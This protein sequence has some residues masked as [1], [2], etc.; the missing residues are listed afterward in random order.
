MPAN[1]SHLEHIDP[2]TQGMA[3]AANTKV[4]EPGPPQ[5]FDNASL[6]ILIHGDASFPGQGIVSET[7]SLSRLPGYST[8]GSLH[9][10]TNNQLGFTAMENESRSSLH[11]SDLAKGFEIPIIHV[12][13]DDPQACIE[14]A[15]T[16][17]AYRHKFHKD[18]VINLIGYP[19]Y[20]HNKRD[21]PRFTHPVTYQKVN[22]H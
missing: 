22:N 14:A 9:I 18:F 13:A 8:S 19:R 2:V 4:D 5:Y 21:K 12:N 15:H 16:A 17:F 20:E 7:L 3:R 11:A 1:P 6:P 10:I